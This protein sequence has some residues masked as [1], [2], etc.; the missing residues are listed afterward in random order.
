MEDTFD[1]QGKR[2]MFPANVSKPKKYTWGWSS[3]EAVAE[4][5]ETP[6]HP[7]RLHSSADGI[8]GAE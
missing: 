6:Q 4:K 5:A 2:K 1:R 3:E 7:G 8:V